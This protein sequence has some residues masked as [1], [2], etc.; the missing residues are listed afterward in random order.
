[1]NAFQDARDAQMMWERK[2]AGKREPVNLN[3][4]RR[5]GLLTKVFKTTIEKVEPRVSR[6]PAYRH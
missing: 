6:Q 2:F 4:G 1:M 3:G 5:G